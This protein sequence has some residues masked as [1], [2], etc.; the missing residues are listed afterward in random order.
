MRIP[1]SVSAFDTIVK[2]GVPSG[3][4]VIL[5]GEPGAGNIE[6]S[7]TSAA[8]LSIA[9]KDKK[10]RNLMIED[11][12]DIYIPEGTTY[13]SF[14]KSREEVMR[15]V[16]ITFDE[17]LA[18]AMKENLNFKDFSVEYF[19][20]SIVPRK[21][22]SEDISEFFKRKGELLKE[23]VKFI[24]ENSD[25]RIVIVDSLTDLAISPRINMKDLV[26]VIKALR[27]NSKKWNSVIYLLLTLGIIDKKDENLLFDSVDGV[28]LFEWHSSTK[29]SKRYRHMYVLKFV[30]LMSWL[31]EERIARFNT[32]LNRKNGFVVINTEK[33]G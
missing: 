5:A 6:F 3:S 27:R 32:M 22:V 29:Y 24:D 9:R 16:D 30:G 23:F 25:G 1:T 33:I 10:F 2:G 12:K 13:I 26:D 4:V 28:M 11:S 7:Y 20:N 17:D 8:K 31:E 21:W 19:K 18:R 15:A 14:S